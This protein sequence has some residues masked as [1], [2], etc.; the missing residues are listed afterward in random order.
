MARKNRTPHGQ[1]RASQGD[2][3]TNKAWADAQQ[4]GQGR[5]FYDTETGAYVVRGP[6]ERI[7]LFLVGGD[8]KLRAHTSF[9]NRSK[10]TGNRL[11]TGKWRPLSEDEYNQW[12]M[13]LSGEE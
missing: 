5:M 4:A 3:P 1:E 13:L 12:R 6:K 2:R 11:K 8:G 9:D 7:H 10:N